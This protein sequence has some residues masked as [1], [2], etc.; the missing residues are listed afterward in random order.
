MLFLASFVA[1]VMGFAA[2]D[3]ED[4]EMPRFQYDENGR[5]YQPD[6][7]PISYAE[8][9]KYAEGNGWKYVSS[10]EID[11]KGRVLKRGYYENMSGASSNNYYFEKDRYSYEFF[12]FPWGRAYSTTSYIYQEDGNRIGHINRFDDSFFT[13]FQV[14]SI[15]ENEL[16]V[17]EY[18]AYRSGENS[19]DVYGLVTYRKMTDEECEDYLYGYNNYEARELD[20]SFMFEK[21]GDITEEDFQ[22]EVVGYG[23]QWGHTWEISEDTTYRPEVTY[24]ASEEETSHYYFEKDVLTRF[25]RTEDGEFVHSKEPYTLM[26]DEFPYKLVNEATQDTL[27]LYFSQSIE[28][29]FREVIDTRDGKPV[30]GFSSYRRMGD[31]KLQL[32]REKYSTEVKHP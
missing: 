15:D 22:K 13:Q 3:G 17:V 4:V 27:Y 31:K 19:R 16:Q 5:C 26:L 32:F 30:W 12:S 28:L 18:L 24:Y 1:I 9:L 14:L 20:A 7:Q 21:F 23:W 10:Y 6:A 25:Y 2:C 11:E 29:D 8:F